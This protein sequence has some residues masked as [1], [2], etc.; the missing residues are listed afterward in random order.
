M[1]R[2][3]S[4]RTDTPIKPGRVQDIYEREGDWLFVDVGFSKNE[5]SCGVL[6]NDGQPKTVKFGGLVRCVVKEA[7]KETTTPLNLVLEAPL[8]VTFDKD[9]NPTPRSCDR[10][11]GK[12]RDWY[13]GSA[14]SLIVAT[15]HL[16]RDLEDAKSRIHREVRLFEGFVSFKPKGVK[17]NHKRDVKKLRYAVW[18]PTPEYIVKPD[19]LPRDECDTP[20]SA[21]KFAGMDFGTP[22]VLF[23]QPNIILVGFMA[24]GKSHVGRIL[25]ERTGMPLVDADT[26][27]VERAGKSIEQIFADAKEKAFRSLEREVIAELC[28]RSGQIISAGGGAFVAP[29]NRRELLSGGTVFCLRARPETIY[30]RLRTDNESGQ[31][32]RPLLAGPDPLGRIRELLAKRAEAYEQAHHCVDTDNLTPEEVAGRVSS[33]F[34]SEAPTTT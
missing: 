32:V 11:D 5:L 21:F 13:H 19:Q 7:T 26:L 9:H 22:P 16:L 33:L 14:P 2:N 15:G 18:N 29:H 23:P 20:E 8:S 1:A 4:S 6:K 30:Q 31:A 3:H 25:S 10:R 17:S 28:E 27:I 12:R 24:S 34:D